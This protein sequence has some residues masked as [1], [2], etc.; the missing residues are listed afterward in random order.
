MK[1]L[2]IVLFVIS[3]L[4]V[5]SVGFDELRTQFVRANSERNVEKMEVVIDLTENN[6]NDAS[7]M[8]L[9]AEAMTEIANWGYTDDAIRE[10][11][12]EK[13]VE[14][15][16]AAVEIES[17]TYTNYV[18][19]AAIGRLAQYKGIVSSL[20]MLGD[21]DDYISTAIE[22][23][24]NNFK[25]LVAMGMRYRDTPWPAGNN[26]KSEQYLKQAIE[27]EPTYINSYYE[28]GILY[29]EWGKDEE[30]IE[31]FEEVLERP[32]H[33]NFVAQGEEAKMEA[34]KHLEELR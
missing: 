19:G 20:F 3:S 23:D 2:M 24:P 11:M 1:K 34:E 9:N 4:M 27:A 10:D 32:V 29:K 13:A 6:T 7:I 17:T 15:G 12:Y 22:L 30:A 18:A 21:F 25:A 8:A 28:L 5:F 14:K 31:M 16:E 33:P 26:K